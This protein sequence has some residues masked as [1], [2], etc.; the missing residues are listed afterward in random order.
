MTTSDM[1]RVYTHGIPLNQLIKEIGTMIIVK[2]KVLSNKVGAI[3]F[4]KVT[5][6]KIIEK[7]KEN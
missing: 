3:S 7:A 2:E 6:S 1:A 5:G 4:T